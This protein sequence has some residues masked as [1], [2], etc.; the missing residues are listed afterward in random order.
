M[1][2]LLILDYQ[3]E[4]IGTCQ[5]RKSIARIIDKGQQDYLQGILSELENMNYSCVLEPPAGLSSSVRSGGIK[6]SQS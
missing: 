4:G 6:A 3:G 5:S 1:V 2:Y